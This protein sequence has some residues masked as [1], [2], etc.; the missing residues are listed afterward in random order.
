VPSG[1]F[2]VRVIARGCDTLV[3]EPLDPAKLPAQMRLAL[4]SVPGVSGRV[5]RGGAP[6]QGAKVRLFESAVGRGTVQADG[7]EARFLPDVRSTDTTDSDGRFL[8]TLREDG[9]F[10]VVA[11]LEGE[12]V[13]EVG[14][15]DLRKA[16]GLAELE[17]EHPRGGAIEGRVLVSPGVSPEGTIVA[18]N[19]GDLRPRSMRVGPEG[20]FRFD[21]LAPGAWQVL[22]SDVE[23]A[24]RPRGWAVSMNARDAHFDTQCEVRAGAVT[25]YDID[26]VEA[27]P[28]KLTGRLLLNGDAAAGWTV[29]LW[30]DASAVSNAELP[31]TALDDDGR[32]SLASPNLGWRRLHFQHDNPGEGRL[33]LVCRLELH[34]GEQPWELDLAVGRVVGT[35]APSLA[36]S[37]MYASWSGDAGASATLGFTP[38]VTGRFELSE[39]PA[40]KLVFREQVT[41]ADGTKEWREIASVDV[42]KG[43]TASVALQ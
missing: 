9:P 25:R 21:G 33:Y 14:P 37:P 42:S 6:V 23:V 31:S 35:V 27:S 1:A 2:R 38:D 17:L 10:F 5:V 15:L 36:S 32:F 34:P 12:P 30:P 16:I 4:T 3:T 18:A 29:T 41:Q 13:A 24:K 26:L 43:A 22:R 19:R 39:V 11:E 8:L 40:G 28:C 7:F 20:A